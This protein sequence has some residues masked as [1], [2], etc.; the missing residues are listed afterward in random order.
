MPTPTA[1]ELHTDMESV[2]GLTEQVGVDGP[3]S[4]DLLGDARRVIRKVSEGLASYPADVVAARNEARRYLARAER[5]ERRLVQLNGGLAPLCPCT[6]DP[7]DPAFGPQ[8]ECPL[9]GDQS[10]FVEYVRWLE[11]IREA[12]QAYRDAPTDSGVHDNAGDMYERL[13]GVLRGPVPAPPRP[14]L[15]E[16]RAALG[17]KGGA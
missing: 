1:A 6:T 16:L 17:A 11:Q 12:A 9:D 7:N 13:L 14:T 5:A 2:L 3:T 15:D 10:T 4:A 8:Q